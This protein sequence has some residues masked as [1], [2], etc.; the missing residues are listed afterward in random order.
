MK[1]YSSSNFF[2]ETSSRKFLRTSTPYSSKISNFEKKCMTKTFLIVL[3]FF[4]LLYVI[5][6][7][8]KHVWKVRLQQKFWPVLRPPKV[9]NFCLSRTFSCQSKVTI[10]TFTYIS[11]FR[12]HLDLKEASQCQ[13]RSSLSFS[14]TISLISSQPKHH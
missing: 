7:K 2:F 8:N 14:L 5:R 13:S 6:K 11:I 10:R 12:F 9:Y 3:D 1:V 4:R